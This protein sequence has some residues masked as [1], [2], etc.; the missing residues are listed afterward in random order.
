MD[1]IPQRTTPNHPMASAP[2]A[3]GKTIQATAVTVIATP[4]TVHA[5]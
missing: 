1:E 4:N 3:V 2:G 5:A